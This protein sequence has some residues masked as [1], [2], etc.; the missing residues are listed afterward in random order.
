MKRFWAAFLVS[1][2]LFG[3]A[4]I[5]PCSTSVKGGTIRSVGFPKWFWQERNDGYSHYSTDR[6]VN[7]L[8]NAAFAIL[9][10]YGIGRWYQTLG[11]GKVD[12]VAG[13]KV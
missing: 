13:G 12:Y 11:K 1:L 9:V 2:A 4:N 8:F 6:P 10:S 7:L 5:A 3:V